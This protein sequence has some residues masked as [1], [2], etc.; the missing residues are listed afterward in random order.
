MRYRNQTLKIRE[1]NI[2]RG[3]VLRGETD[4]DGAWL[5]PLRG[6]SP[7]WVQPTAMISC[8]W[9]RK[10]KLNCKPAVILDV[11]LVTPS[12]VEDVDD[13]Y[14]VWIVD[15]VSEY[16]SSYRHC[17]KYGGANCVFNARRL[18]IRARVQRSWSFPNNFSVNHDCWAFM[19]YSLSLLP[20]LTAVSV[21]ERFVDPKSSTRK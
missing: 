18:L 10:S 4:A 20:S 7:G 1:T 21:H 9:L 3:T 8:E 15:R 6:H 2:S 14:A 11:A 16:L 17:A 19:P 13:I 12:E 5:W